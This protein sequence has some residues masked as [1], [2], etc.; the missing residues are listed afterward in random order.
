MIKPFFCPDCEKTLDLPYVPNRKRCPDCA[1]AHA[2]IHDE[3]T[4]KKNREIYRERKQAK[5]EQA[6]KEKAKEM[7]PQQKRDAE[8]DAKTALQLKQ[9]RKCEYCRKEFGLE[10]CDFI[11]WHGHSTDKGNSP[12]DCRSF[13][14]RGT[15]GREERMARR[16]MALARSEADHAYT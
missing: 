12:G 8:L 7:T 3:E 2:K 9:C 1:H 16:K 13:L 5:R 6:A 14:K 15:K 4:R 10:Y 11:S